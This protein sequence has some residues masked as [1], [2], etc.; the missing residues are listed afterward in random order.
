M[1]LPPL[2]LFSLKEKPPCCRVAFSCLPRFANGAFSTCARSRARRLQ[3]LSRPPGAR[4][5]RC[6]LPWVHPT[7][8]RTPEGRRRTFSLR[9]AIACT[10][11]LPH[12]Q[13]RAFPLEH[14]CEACRPIRDGSS[15]PFV[16][17]GPLGVPHGSPYSGKCLLPRTC[18][19]SLFATGRNF[20]VP[21]GDATI[22]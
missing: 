16:K 9:R 2:E 14:V 4:P 20:T 3:P 18:M 21:G 15:D 10:R 7:H 13:E 6:R 22:H 8:Q 17:E 12:R 11:V 1:A 5:A 19:P